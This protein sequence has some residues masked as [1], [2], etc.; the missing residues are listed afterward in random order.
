MANKKPQTQHKPRFDYKQAQMNAEKKKKRRNQIYAY[1]LLFFFLLWTVG[2]ALSFIN[3]F[4]DK[5]SMSASAESASTSSE[6]TENGLGIDL[7]Q[8][9]M[10]NLIPYPYLD[11]EGTISNGITWTVNPDGTVIADGTASNGGSSFLVVGSKNLFRFNSSDSF[12]ISGVPAGYSKPTDGAYMGL[13]IKSSSGEATTYKVVSD[14]LSISP[15][16]GYYV[17]SWRLY[18]QAGVTVN[19]LV[20]SPMITKGETVYPYMPSKADPFTIAAGVPDDYTISK[21]IVK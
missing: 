18:I 15:G 1:I 14:G 11:G 16:A 19:N 21:K 4:G 6:G 17:A 9:P 5:N 2:T 10:A 13:S 12:R 20:F 7:S 8:Y 3:F